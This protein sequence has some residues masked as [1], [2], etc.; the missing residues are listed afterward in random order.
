LRCPTP[1]PLGSLLLPVS[2][3][4]CPRLQYTVE[5]TELPGKQLELLEVTGGTIDDDDA[6]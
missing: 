6:A 5:M 1:F 4:W 3:V 2:C